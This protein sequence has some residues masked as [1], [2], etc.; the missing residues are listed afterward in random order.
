M[1]IPSKSLSKK[2]NTQE[3]R[4]RRDPHSLNTVGGA[5]GR[6]LREFPTHT[7]QN[8]KKRHQLGEHKKKKKK[9]FEG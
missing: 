3:G 8:T 9:T 2:G 5:R 6:K 1:E 7:D 4:R